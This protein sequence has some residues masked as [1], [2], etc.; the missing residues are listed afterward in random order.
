MDYRGLLDTLSWSKL[1]EYL[2]GESSLL[3]EEAEEVRDSMRRFRQRIL[4][5]RKLRQRIFSPELVDLEEAWSLLREGRVAGVDGTL[6]LYPTPIGFRCRIGVVAVNYVGEKISEA[7]YI[8]D[9]MLIDEELEKIEDILE[10]IERLSK[11]SPLL[12]RS[13]MLHKEREFA[14][15]RDEE[16][17]ILHG[18]LVPLEMRLGRLGVP[19]ALE[20]NLELGRKLVEYGKVIGV[21]SSTNRLRLLN[22]GYVLKPGEYMLVG[23]AGRLMEAEKR[24][25]TR[26][27]ERL[28]DEFIREYGSRI[29]VGIY[30]VSSKAYIFEAVDE[31]FHDAAKIVMADSVNSSVKGFPLLLDYADRVLSSILSSQAFMERIEHSLLKAGGEEAFIAFSERRMRW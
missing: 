23:N 27:E 22:L 7:V 26:E 9:A 18:P 30:R 1:E 16:W 13:I 31:F 4:G 3:E 29:I 17:K 8:S 6:S 28:L 15:S 21:L 2:V 25:V 12:Y 19:G 24:R 5:I 14:L 20:A 10:E 11:L